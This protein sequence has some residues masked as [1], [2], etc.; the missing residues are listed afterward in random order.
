MR[1]EVKDKHIK[2]IT[3]FCG[4]KSAILFHSSQN[5]DTITHFVFMKGAIHIIKSEGGQVIGLWDAPVQ[6]VC[7]KVIYSSELLDYLF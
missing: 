2:K 3:E 1:E 4:K 7:E 6:L 5:Y